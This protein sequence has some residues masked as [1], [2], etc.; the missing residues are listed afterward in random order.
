LNVGVVVTEL[1]DGRFVPWEKSLE[2]ESYLDFYCLALQRR[3]HKCIKYV[4]SIGV[5]K[6]ES[7]YHKFGHKVKRVSSYNNVLAPKTLLRP[8]TYAA[9]QTTILG[10]LL[11]PAFT[12]N[13]M[14]E[15]R[16][17][18]VQVLHYSSYYT[19][20]FVPAFLAALRTPIVTQYTGGM[21]PEGTSGRLLWKI[22]I[23]PSLRAS[24]A[25]LL[26]DYASERKSLVHDLAVPE[27]KQEF[28]N[29]PI[30]DSTVFHELNKQKAQQDLGFDARR[31]NVLCVTYIPTRPRGP[32]VLMKNPYLVID[33]IERAVAAGGGEIKVYVAGWGQGADEFNEY[34][35]ERGMTGRVHLLGQVEH[36]RLPQYYAASD[37]VLVPYGLEKLN[38][39]SATIEAFACCRPVAAFKRDASNLTEQSGGFLVDLAPELGAKTLLD[40]LR[41]PGYLEE[42]GREGLGL[43]HEYTL[44]FAGRRLEEIYSKIV[45]RQE[46]S[47]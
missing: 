18:D 26:G 27:A 2:W 40:R 4:P 3:G 15:A 32:A 37:L 5:A 44:E 9:G 47:R 41:R 25:V 10:Q 12:I 20:F 1:L 7:Y 6:T 28:F 8:R 19:S 38:E 30:I 21:L 24:R 31:K 16:I 39:G 33:I 36:S 43:A 14:K 46:E 42:K 17:D 23:L 11:G 34:V 22:S 13:L 35:R 29:A 45:K